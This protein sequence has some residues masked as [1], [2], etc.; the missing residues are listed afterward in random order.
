MLEIIIKKNVSVF[1]VHPL[2]RPRVNQARLLEADSRVSL[3]S[4]GSKRVVC[5]HVL[6]WKGAVR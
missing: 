6:S 2:N 1:M 4:Y 5:L 3:P